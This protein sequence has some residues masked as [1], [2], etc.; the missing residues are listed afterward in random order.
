MRSRFGA[1]ATVGLA[2]LKED[3]IAATDMELTAV[4]EFAAIWRT[5]PPP[6]RR[7][8]QTQGRRGRCLQIHDPRRSRLP[9]R[10]RSPL[11]SGETTQ[12]DVD[13]RQTGERWGIV[14][15]SRVNVPGKIQP[16][17]EMRADPARLV[18]KSWS[19]IYGQKID[20]QIQEFQALE[21]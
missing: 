5:T 12:R 13:G 1:Q 9:C 8:R 4:V 10:H 20:G 15:S 3:I 14:F 2:E 21:Q 17:T 11:P 7:A 6:L 16:V 19:K 18:H